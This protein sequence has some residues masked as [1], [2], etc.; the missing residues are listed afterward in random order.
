MT[1]DCE[2]RTRIQMAGRQP[3]SAPGEWLVT[4]GVQN[5]GTS[6]LELTQV[7]LPHGQ[8][9]APR[10]DIGPA[11]HI[12]PGATIHLDIHVACPL[13]PTGV[14]ENAFVIL[15]VQSEGEPWRVFAR[16]RVTFDAEGAPLPLTEQITT[17]RAFPGL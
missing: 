13:P 11:L 6:P 9:R 16:L 4:W 15:T 17:Q 5:L 14:V 1:T 10:Q 12:A 7:W 2:P 8:F 3:A